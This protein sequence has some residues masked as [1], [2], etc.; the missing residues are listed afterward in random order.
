MKPLFIVLGFPF[1]FPIAL[2]SVIYTLGLHAL[3]LVFFPDTAHKGLFDE[4]K[5]FLGWGIAGD[6][7]LFR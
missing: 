1:R 7:N 6:K 4:L 2:F 3:L 5:Q